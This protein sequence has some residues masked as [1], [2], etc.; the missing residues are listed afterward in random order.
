MPNTLDFEYILTPKGIMPN[1][2]LTLDSNGVIQ[3]ISESTQKAKDGFFALPGMPNAHSHA[4][5]RALA[6]FGEQRQG[7][8]SFWSWREAMYRVANRI[9]PDDL[10][11]IASKAYDEMLLAG[12]TSVAEFHYLHH[13]PDGKPTFAMAEAVLEA[14]QSSGIRLV[15]LPVLYQQGGFDR[16]AKPEQGRFV[17]QKLDDYLHLLQRLKHVQVGIAPHSLRAVPMSDLTRLLEG[18][19]D[20]LGQDFPIHI[21]I[22]EQ[23]AE[24]EQCVERYSR[25]PIWCLSDSV[26]LDERWS[27]V[28]ATHATPEELRLVRRVSAEVVLCPLT[29]AYLGDGIFPTVEYFDFGGRPAVGS[30]SNV[31]IDA[32]SELRWMEYSQ[33]LKNRGRAQLANE[34]GVG[35]RLWSSA[36]AGG[37]RC[38]RQSVAGVS[39][40]QYADLVVL[41]KDAAP[42]LGVGPAQLMDAWLVAGDRHCIDQVF[43]G[44]R[45][46]VKDGRLIKPSTKS[47]D[48]SATMAR[49]HQ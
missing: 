31:R 35:S 21:H 2:R 42:L 5:Q 30:D 29:E 48:F 9:M 17:H 7:Q 15:F 33:R 13:W 22:S 8:D 49:L 3:G 38:L 1:C 11:T 25:T 10:L 16:P 45:Q 27:L 14:A 44:G 20:V 36:V 23:V 18:V 39:P 32:M 12:F 41:N 47:A 26:D 6:G 43:V 46:R 40:G 24:V 28:H 34:Y 37:A 4:F 19:T